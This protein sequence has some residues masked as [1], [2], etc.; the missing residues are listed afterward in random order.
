[1]NPA[2]RG[3]GFHSRMPLLRLAMAL[4]V[5]ILPCQ[6]VWSL[7]CVPP[8]PLLP[9]HPRAN[10]VGGEILSRQEDGSL[11]IRVVEVLQGSVPSGSSSSERLRLDSRSLVT[12]SFGRLPFPRGSRWLFQLAAADGLDPGFDAALSPCDDPLPVTDGSVRG[13]LFAG[14]GQQGTQAMTIEDLRQRIGA[15]S[16]APSPERLPARR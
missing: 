15:R 5:L 2:Q 1:M 6:R 12:W 7:S 4:V 16:V 8:A 13:R 10:V 14:P 9:L 3:S 11:L